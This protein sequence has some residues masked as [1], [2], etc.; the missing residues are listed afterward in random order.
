MDTPSWADLL[1]EAFPNL[2]SE[3]FETVGQASELYNCIAYVAEDTSKWWWPD[4][5]NY[6]PPWA[7]LD[8]KMESL[9]EALAGLGYE[10]CD[11]SDPED[12]Y[13]KVALYEIQGRFQHAAVQMSNG[14][15]RSKMGQGPVVEHRNPES[16]SGGPYGN[17]K[18]F[19]RR[20]TVTTNQH[21]TNRL[22]L[23]VAA[24]AQSN[25]QMR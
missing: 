12:G 25:P 8:T 4:G 5:T 14:R 20:A 23:A 1:V 7:T 17:P 21:G 10:Q 6:W 15:W 11:D 9:K 24:V 19:M 22:P 13:Q 18:V 16:L 2:A 3:G